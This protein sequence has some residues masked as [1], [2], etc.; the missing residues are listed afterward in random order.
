MSSL[1]S[2]RGGIYSGKTLEAQIQLLAEITGL[3]HRLQVA[4]GGGDD[5]RLCGQ[6]LVTS[7]AFKRALFQQAQ[8]L[9]S[10]SPTSS[11]RFHPKTRCR[12]WPVLPCLFRW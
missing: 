9:I 7:N 6:R 12:L 1:C 4:A 10:A 5:A 8:D 3:H 2:R 11:R